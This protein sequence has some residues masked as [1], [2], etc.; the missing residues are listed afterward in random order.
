MNIVVY[1]R[2]T[3]FLTEK[4]KKIILE[5]AKEH[6]L[7]ILKIYIDKPRKRLNRTRILIYSKSQTFDAV[8]VYKL[9]ELDKR[10]KVQNKIIS[11]LRKNNVIVISVLDSITTDKPDSEAKPF[12]SP[13]LIH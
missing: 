5:Y 6:N 2:K 13:C 11:V 8:L 10:P 3:A 9:S 7:N 12:I 4:K 1:I